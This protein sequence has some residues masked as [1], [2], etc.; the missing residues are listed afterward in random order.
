MKLKIEIAC[1]NAAFG[2]TD[3]ERSAE[4]SRI[5][6]RLSEKLWLGGGDDGGKL[7]DINGNTVGE[8]SVG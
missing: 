8:W 6:A 1:D 2:E 4:L 7:R 5:L 3:E